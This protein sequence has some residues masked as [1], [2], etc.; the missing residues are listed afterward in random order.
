MLAVAA[1][2][3]VTGAAQAHASKP[4]QVQMQGVAFHLDPSIVLDIRYLRGELQRQSPDQPPYLDDKH[5]FTLA[6]DSARIGITPAGLSDLLNRYTFAYP[7]SP[8]RKLAITLEHG[9]V[10]QQGVMR[11]VSFAVVGDLSVDPGGELRLHPTSIKAA[12]I[13]VGGLMKFFG[14]HLQKLV[15]TQRARGVRIDRDDFLLSPAELLPPPK[16]AGRLAAV[17][18]TD[19]EIIQ[20]FRPPAGPA[21]HALLLP[22]VH[23]P[24]Y[25]FFR[26]GVLRFGK[27]TM[28]DTDLLILDAAPGDP[29]DF[30]LD[31]YNQQLVAGYSRNTPDHGLIVT[32][33]D[34]RTTLRPHAR[35]PTPTGV[36]TGGRPS[37]SQALPPR[38]KS[39]I[40]RTSAPWGVVQPL[41][42]GAKASSPG[43]TA[44]LASPAVASASASPTRTRRRAPGASR[45]GSWR[46]VVLRLP[47]PST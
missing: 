22:H 20:L 23:A 7:G 12:G 11:G 32:M 37:R 35:L 4:V 13:K 34:Y 8:L 14:L 24:N 41:L 30:F 3:P 47:Y 5:S 28:V 16:V 18:V 10:R 21:A 29:F 17:E 45:P 27:L 26:D 25:M 40:Q 19:S 31:H 9:R 15:D 42:P 33:P 43:S 46:M 2:L 6:I 38:R 39:S 1:A 36:P 44:K